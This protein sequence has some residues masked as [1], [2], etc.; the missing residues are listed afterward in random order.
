SSVY[1]DFRFRLFSCLCVYRL[2]QSFP[3]RR[4]SDLAGAWA[5][6]A[7]HVRCRRRQPLTDGR[8]FRLLHV[9]YRRN[10]NGGR[11]R[12]RRDLAQGPRSE[13]HTSELQSREKLVCRLLHEK[14]KDKA[15][16]AQKKAGRSKKKVSNFHHIKQ[17]KAI[18][19]SNRRKIH[20]THQ[21][22]KHLRNK[23]TPANDIQP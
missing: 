7:R 19:T 17:L 11:S 20:T 3:T 16:K 2:L 10:G 4:S 18:E 5:L 14:K 6:E 22:I 9:R 21:K 12:H 1:S 15:T 13:E 23:Q 8:C